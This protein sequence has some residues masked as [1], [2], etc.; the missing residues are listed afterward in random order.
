MFGPVFLTLRENLIVVS[1]QTCSSSS[2][3]FVMS[4]AGAHGGM[5]HALE[6]TSSVAGWPNTSVQD[7][8]A[9]LS[10][11][12]PPAVAGFV[13]VHDTEPPGARFTIDG[14]AP[15][16]SV[17]LT[18]QLARMFGPVFLT[19][20][21]NLIVVSVQTCSSSSQLFVMST[22]G[23]GGG[24]NSLVLPIAAPVATAAHSASVVTMSSGPVAAR[25]PNRPQDA[26]PTGITALT[27]IVAI[28]VTPVVRR[29][30]PVVSSRSII[31]LLSPN[32]VH[33]STPAALLTQPLAPTDTNCSVPGSSVAQVV[34]VH[35]MVCV[36]APMSLALTAVP[37]AGTVLDVLLTVI[38][39]SFS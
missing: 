11:G 38:R 20:R 4:T 32:A 27:L 23:G 36:I 24:K 8:D 25:S 34:S 26:G 18:V 3:L 5:L 9:L 6:V 37:G 15:V 30:T 12:G 13:Q 33:E 7:T 35:A 22:A 10:T 19:L 17:S 16:Q 14:I 28:G 39:I 29:V 1:V 21:E 31:T 2:Q